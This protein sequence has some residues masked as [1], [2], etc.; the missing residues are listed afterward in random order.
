MATRKNPE[1]GKLIPKRRGP[2][3][4]PNNL[5]G[6]RPKSGAPRTNAKVKK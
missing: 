5:G 1:G 4:H 3:P 6:T 2:K